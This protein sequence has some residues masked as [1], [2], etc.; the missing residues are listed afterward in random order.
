MSTNI[1]VDIN[2]NVGISMALAVSGGFLAGYY[3]SRVLSTSSKNV[4][5]DASSEMDSPHTNGSSNSDTQR[6]NAQY[7]QKETSG[8]AGNGYLEEVS[9]ESLV[10]ALLVRLD[11]ELSTGT[12]AKHCSTACLGQFKKLYKIKST[13]LRQWEVTNGRKVCFGV[14][15]EEEMLAT[16]AAA[17]TKGIPTR[18]VIDEESRK[19]VLAVGPAPVRELNPLLSE[20]KEL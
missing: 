7:T 6:F 13:E 3:V 19:V 8:T 12:T 18:T 11:L 10:L 4:L 20:L 15:D 17:R 5:P 1:K 14:N 16:Q 9:D 2:R